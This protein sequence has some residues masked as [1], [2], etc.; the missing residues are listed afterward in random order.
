[1]TI[2]RTCRYY[3]LKLLRLKGTPHSIALGSAIGVFIGITPTMPFHTLLIFFTTLFSR[4]S[5][6]AGLVMSWLVCNPFTYI[7]QYYFSMLIG[8][9]V[10][11]YEM[12]WNKIKAVLDFM[13]SDVSINLKVHTFINLGI[14]TI[15]ILVTGG[16]L[17]AFPFAIASYYIMYHLS[18]KRRRRHVI[19]QIKR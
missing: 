6:F 13:L 1:M 14:E 16:S 3:Y 4:A 11:P 17:L 8:N 18:V 7:P 2:G 5:F 9:A 15:V 12:N 19:S 10:T